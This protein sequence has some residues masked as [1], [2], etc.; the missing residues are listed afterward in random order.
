MRKLAAGADVLYLNQIVREDAETRWLPFAPKTARFE[1][2]TYRESLIVRD[3][4]PVNS[5]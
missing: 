4:P 3:S 5:L 1:A 2:G